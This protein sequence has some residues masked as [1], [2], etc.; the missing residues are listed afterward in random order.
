MTSG[1]HLR[2]EPDVDLDALVEAPLCGRCPYGGAGCCESPPAFSWADV[3]RIVIHGGDRFVREE[4]AAGRLHPGQR[5]LRVTLA[6]PTAGRPACC[7]YLGAAGCTLSPERR[8]AT[9]NYY[10]CDELLQSLPPRRAE[11]A[12]HARD[13]LAKRIGRW[14]ERLAR[15]AAAR[16]P[17]GVP[18]D[19]EFLRW[20]GRELEVFA[21]RGARASFR[22]TDEEQ[23]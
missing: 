9:C 3:G 2:V 21:T 11:A 8:S 12:A 5:G 6:A 18:W 22:T 14:D 15:R 17:A 7:G 16:H 19:A 4:L 1:R 10:A 23:R 20:L 13:R